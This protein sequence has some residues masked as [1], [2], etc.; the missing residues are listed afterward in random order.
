MKLS[1]EEQQEIAS[2]ATQCRHRAR[3]RHLDQR[4]ALGARGLAQHHQIA[5][6]VWHFMGQHRQRGDDTQAHVG[7]KRRSDQHTV[8]EGMDAVARQHGPAAALAAVVVA[9]VMLR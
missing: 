2:Q 4:S 7:Q 1:S 5:D 6:V 8:A 9:G 3:Q